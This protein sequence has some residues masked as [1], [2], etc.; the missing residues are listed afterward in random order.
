M[1]AP[2]SIA[3]PKEVLP[4]YSIDV[5]VNF[6]APDKV[7]THESFWML[8]APDGRLF[9]V[10]P[11]ADR[12]IWVT[13]KVDSST[14]I[15]TVA[16]PTPLQPENTP[17]AAVP[18][19]RQEGVVY[20]FAANA[21]SAQWTNNEQPLPCPGLDG[22]KNGFVKID[23]YAQLEN[24]I[25][26]PLPVLV[27]VPS[28]SADGYVQGIYPEREIQAG[29][30]LRALVGCQ[31]GYTACSVLLQVTYRDETNRTS[32]LWSIGEFYDNQYFDLDLDLSPLAGRKIQIILSVSSL[33]NAEGDRALW[34][35]PRIV[36]LQVPTITPIPTATLMPTVTRVP[37]T[38]TVIFVSTSIPP[39]PTATPLVEVGQQGS[40]SIL[41]EIIEW[42][43]SF[44]QGLFGN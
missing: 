42:F 4:G 28:S 39:T 14:A 31:D 37:D 10:G 20:D 26:F 40:P 8:Q 11:S 3:L 13:V 36:H 5:S 22:D 7:D 23:N 44:F 1:G 30:H 24:G 32:D 25:A 29:E 33:G 43:L 19:A 16:L 38:P 12:P 41:E 2:N 6:V 21:C 18:T 27:L 15:P 9:G 35:E 17:V 34:V